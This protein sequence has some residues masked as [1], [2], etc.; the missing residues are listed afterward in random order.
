[1]G[2]VY[3]CLFFD[4]FVVRQSD[5]GGIVKQEIIFVWPNNGTSHTLLAR[6]I[7]ICGSHR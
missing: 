7:Y 3:L 4:H 2:I 6:E 1:M 5:E